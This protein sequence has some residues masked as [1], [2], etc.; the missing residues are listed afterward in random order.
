MRRN[1]CRAGARLPELIARVL[2]SRDRIESK[3]DCMDDYLIGVT[4]QLTADTAEEAH[5]RASRALR[6]LQGPVQHCWTDRQA[7]LFTA[8]AFAQMTGQT[9][10]DTDR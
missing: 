2:M 8:A 3:G 5:E 1:A 6:A 10:M 7:E 9:S 4:L